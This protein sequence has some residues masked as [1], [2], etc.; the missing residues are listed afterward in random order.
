MNEMRDLFYYAQ[1]LHQGENTTV[2]RVVTDTVAIE[3]IPNL[4]RAVGYFP[5][6]QEVILARYVVRDVQETSIL[7]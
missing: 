3:K 6:D 5:S 4:A 2:A 1:I 7:L